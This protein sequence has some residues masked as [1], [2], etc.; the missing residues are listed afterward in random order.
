MKKKILAA[1]LLFVLTGISA[2]SGGTQTCSASGLT[3]GRT[4]EYGYE[5]SD[6]NAVFGTFRAE[7]PTHDIPGVDSSIDCGSVG[8]VM[9][10]SPLIA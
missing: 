2:C 8:F 5:D 6:G 10:E 4:Y 1:L 7:G 3:A 9:L